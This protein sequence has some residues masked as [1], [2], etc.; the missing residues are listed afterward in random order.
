L[1]QYDQAS[2]L[3]S[4][5][6]D[7]LALERKILTPEGKAEIVVASSEELERV[8]D[9]LKDIGEL[10]GIID[11]PEFKGLEKLFSLITPIESKHV[12]QIAQSNKASARI[13]H[14]L[15]RYN[16]ITN[17]L[18]EIFITWDQMLTTIDV[19]ISALERKAR[20]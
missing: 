16:R 13:T 2:S 15:D 10:Q 12:D 4:P 8:A 1:E 6:V 14:L 17:T 7:N 20:Q 19:H 5:F 9:S 18:S 3:V 11:A